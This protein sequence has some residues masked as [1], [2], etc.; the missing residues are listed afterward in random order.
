MFGENKIYCYVD[1][2]ACLCLYLPSCSSLTGRIHI[3]VFKSKG[4][5]TGLNVT[6]YLVRYLFRILLFWI[7][8]FNKAIWIPS[9]IESFFFLRSK[10]STR[11]D[12]VKLYEVLN[13]VIL[14]WHHRCFQTVKRPI[15]IWINFEFYS[16][17]VWQYC[18]TT[19]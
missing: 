19:E 13:V 16:T 4:I 3:S 14:V 8:V 2:D 9:Q 11:F 15:S 12:A 1:E 18:H 17:I 5:P 6:F 10:A 7:L